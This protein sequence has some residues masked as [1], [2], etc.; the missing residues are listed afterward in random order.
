MYGYEQHENDQFGVTFNDGSATNFTQNSIVD[1]GVEEAFVE[2]NYRPTSWLTLIAGER[3]SHFQGTVTENAIY[4]RLG[5]AIQIPHLRWVL[6]GFY[7][8]FYQPPPL[9]SITGP[10]LAYAHSSNFGFVPLRGERDEEH[11]FGLQ[12]PWR[13]WTRIPSRRK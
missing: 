11:Q 7:G 1:G 8:H 5:M 12:I 4:P 6:R 3:Q 9:T 2:D 10:A 13:G